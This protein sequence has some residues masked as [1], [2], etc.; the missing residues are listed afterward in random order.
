MLR[1]M[2]TVET[3]SV[4][5]MRWLPL[6]VAA[7]SWAVTLVVFPRPVAQWQSLHDFADQRLLLGIPNLFNVLSNLPFLV[8]GLAGLRFCQTR[9][10]A[11]CRLPWIFFFCG[12]ALV[13]VGSAYY[14]WAPTDE[15]L[16]WDRLPLTLAFISLL[17]A[18]VGDFV[19]HRLAQWLL[20]PALLLGGGS[21]AWWMWF[22]DVRFYFWVQ[23][24]PLLVI[25]LMAMGF[26]E[27]RP[28]LRPLCIAVSWYVA[29]KL[30]ELFDRPVLELTGGIVSGHSI[31]HLLA[32]VACWVIY[33]M[34]VQMK[35]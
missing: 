18:L 34:L 35:Q 11:V 27:A 17:I 29:A 21:V 22:D 2:S 9:L 5:R 3:T 10:E 24:M 20:A 12:V 15:T 4:A 13:S 8:V 23:F 7:G 33:R 19:S 14:H 6:M 31:K 1:A 30:F 26:E 16:A 25:P 32:A 28:R